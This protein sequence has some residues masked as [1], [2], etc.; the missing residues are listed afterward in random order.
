MAT[1]PKANPLAALR[2]L[3][4]S[5]WLSGVSRAMLRDGSLRRLIEDDGL[6]GLTWNLTTAQKAVSSGAEYDD[7]I[8]D[9]VAEGK[10]LEA[11]AE[12]LAAADAR[13]ALDLLRPVYE[14][15]D[16]GDGFVSIGVSPLLAHDT[17]GTIA[18]AKALWA[19]LDRPN[20]MVQI[21]A[22]PEG[23]AA[24]EEVLYAG[25]N[26]D[27]TLLFSVDTYEQVARV[28]LSALN[29]RLAEGRPVDRVASVASVQVSRIGAEID[30]WIEAGLNAVRDP[31]LTAR[32]QGLRGKAADASARDGY[33]VFRR[34]FDGPEFTPL[35]AKG[36]KAQ[37]RLWVAGGAED[38]A[39]IDLAGLIGPRTVVAMPRAALETLKDHGAS[40]PSALDEP[41]D[42]T[43]TFDELVEAGIDVPGAADVL[44]GEDVERLRSAYRELLGALGRKRDEVIAERRFGQVLMLGASAGAAER[45]LAEF[46][47]VRAIERVWGRDATLWAKGPGQAESIR[48]SLG[49]LRAGEAVRP[50]VEELR[51]FG[52]DLA[53]PGFSHIVVMGVGGSSLCAQVLRR[54]HIPVAGHP[55][56][57][58]LDS[59]VPA[60]IHK[61]E[62][63]VDP[64]HTLFVVASKSGTTT[65]PVVFHA[66]FHEVVKRFKQA[67]AG[68]NFV[69][70]TDPGTLLEAQATRDTFRRTFLNP[71]DVPGRYGALSYLGTVPAAL[72]GLDIEALLDRARVAVGACSAEVPFGRNPG[73]LLGAALGALARS[74]RDKV[75][76]V[77]PPPLEA[78]G[79][80]LEQL[81]AESTGKQGTGI[82]PVAGEPLGGPEVYGNDRVFVQVRTLESPGAEE[83]PMLRA[84]AQ[85][86]H[87]VIDL[88]MADATDLFAE[89]FRW[90]FAVPLAASILGVNPYDQPDGQ[91]SKDH[92]KAILAGLR[93]TG[94]VPEL[95][96][97]GSFEGLTLLADPDGEEQAAPASGDDRGAVVKALR[98]HFARVR[99]GGYIAL[100][101]FFDETED[102][103]AVLLAIRTHL[104]D[105]LNVATT[106]GYGPRY[107]HSTG[108]IHKGGPD[109]GVFLQLTGDDGPDLP[110]PGQPFGFATLLGAQALGDFRSLAGRKRAVLRVHLGAEIDKGL[111]TLLSVVRE[112]VAGA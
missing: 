85:A 69:A 24:I 30:R 17:A 72:L 98:D 90:E 55:E 96:K 40:P 97:S 32:L 28:Y 23:L 77:T 15:T 39:T 108:Q 78:I 104:R 4:Q 57:I 5:V 56:L 11:I 2:S 25:V 95:K 37:R 75:T 76:L 84:L 53:G 43:R 92:T 27:V 110:I 54:T 33:A 106:T 35:K 44:L 82:L 112:A 58:V 67:N 88:V 47:K 45:E 73:A 6:Q 87:P 12:G 42:A 10:P 41:G 34:V 20:A 79:L 59:T 9:Q 63:M 109:T 16:G 71:P 19:R 13:A 48:S 50:H 103:D 3:G 68:E 62:G 18:G 61:V 29:R 66:Y 31:V 64:A 86:G 65:E 99:P 52:E 21:P 101:Q 102:R 111:A 91:E 1:A 89:L 36:A 81:L 100:T 70:I 60:A 49:W 51:L 94:G 46:E 105:A 7:A 38:P 8:R 26:V 14:R 83:H 74:G 22:T 107:L 80:W 93:Q